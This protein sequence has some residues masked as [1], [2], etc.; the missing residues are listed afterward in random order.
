MA[1]TTLQ[2]FLVALGFRVDENGLKKF[3]GGLT[4]AAVQVTKL[5]TAVAA[6]QAALTAM[7]KAT[8]SQLETL[9][10][11]AQRSN[12]TVDTL[13][14]LQYGMSQI[15]LAAGDANSA[16]EAMAMSL[17]F[18]PGNEGLL[19]YLQIATRNANGS[20]RDSSAIFH[21]FIKRLST[22]PPF[23]AKMYAEMF[24]IN[25]RT[26]YQ[27]LTNFKDLEKAEERQRQI[28][29][30]TGVD[31]QHSA[32][33]S[34]NFMNSLRE[35]GEIVELMWTK[36]ATVLMEKLGPDLRKFNSWLL[37]HSKEIEGI[38]IAV[39]K[40]ILGVIDDLM[41]VFPYID[42]LIKNTVGWK[43]V[44]EA[45]G[46]II[47]T[48]IFGPL[49][50]AL[51]LAE[52]LWSKNVDKTEVP[53]VRNPTIEQRKNQA[54]ENFWK[55][56]DLKPPGELW[57]GLKRQFQADPKWAEKLGRGEQ[58]NPLFMPQ[59]GSGFDPRMIHPAAYTSGDDAKSREQQYTFLA[60]MSEVFK[61]ALMD[62]FGPFLQIFEDWKTANMQGPGGSATPTG[63][64]VGGPL[65]PKIEAEV[66][67]QARLRGLDEEHMVRLAR[68]EGG[69]F[70]NTSPA[71]AI[72]P[73]QLMPGTAAG[74]GVNPHNWV[75]NIRG[76][77]DYFMQQLRRFG[78][79]AGA[80][81]AY[82]AGPEGRGVSLF[83][84]TGDMSLLPLETQK[85]VLGI[86]G[87]REAVRGAT[88]NQKTD[89]HIHGT[90]PHATARAV[91]EKQAM[92][93]ARLVR[94]FGG[95]VVA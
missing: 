46:V 21:D 72:G 65:D 22:M 45:I 59:S 17:R 80:D 33:I 50:L 70:D 67:K 90:E 87:G 75:E 4:S 32:E 68:A 12:T 23:V 11:I 44:F 71:G 37:S 52:M 35:T 13:K 78:N 89:I 92:I 30:A 26:L 69:G 54:I 93:N 47:M 9:Y 40:S 1:A 51:S 15:G 91:G 94:D 27:L 53:G 49:G 25:E 61:K 14:A 82:N 62:V 19:R 74:L 64:A 88:I 63:T 73:M 28:A 43:T 41:E 79:Y 6:G 48:K 66:R 8:A 42:A 16:L 56:P 3:T 81:A 55:K 58:P 85:Y 84:R 24:G 57:E 38:G 5:A 20:M 18:N 39:G 2:E 77:M 10:Y 31:L 83:A 29:R 76:G 86:N 95:G 34:K 36:V 7:L 60:G